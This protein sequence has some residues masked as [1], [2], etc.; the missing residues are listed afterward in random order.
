MA[1]KVVECPI[2]GD[3]LKLRGLNG[4]LRLKHK[5]EPDEAKRLTAT[6]G[7]QEPVAMVSS[8]TEVNKV[9]LSALKKDVEESSRQDTIWKAIETLKACEARKDD[10][11]KMRESRRIPE[12]V[13]TGLAEEVL[14]EEADTILSLEEL[15]VVTLEEKDK[16]F[17][18]SLW[19]DE[20]DD[21]EDK[22]VWEILKSKGDGGNFS[23]PNLF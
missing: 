17:W 6:A 10:L 11:L 9:A 13:L 23:L 3:Q 16:S 21:G 14:A 2:C 1:E 5:V 8:K 12:D 15:G 4:H 20:D 18:E 7:D 22:D 19:S